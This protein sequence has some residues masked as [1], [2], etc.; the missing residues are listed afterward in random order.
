MNL[1]FNKGEA[2]PRY[3]S[4]TEKLTIPSSSDRRTDCVPMCP[5]V[6]SPR[7]GDFWIG[8]SVQYGN[9][10]WEVNFPLRERCC[11]LLCDVLYVCGVVILGVGVQ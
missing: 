1:F 7:Q 5:V 9:S 4:G 11:H 10:C 2:I 3:S 8:N 6:F